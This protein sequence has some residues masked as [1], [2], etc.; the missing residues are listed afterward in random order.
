MEDEKDIQPPID[1][2]K[3]PTVVDEETTQD[4]LMNNSEVANDSISGASVPFYEELHAVPV[5]D[6]PSKEAAI[7]YSFLVLH[8]PG[9]P[10]Q[11]NEENLR[12][13]PIFP[14]PYLSG[15]TPDRVTQEQL[16][17]GVYINI[18]RSP[19]LWAG[20]Q[21]RLRWGYNTFYTTV[22]ESRGR[23]GPRLVQYL[24]S[25]RLGDY[26]DGI[27]EVL[28]EVVRRSRLIGVSETLRVELHGV[29]KTPRRP[30]SRTRAIRRR[31]LRP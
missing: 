5:T 16:I 20:D 11:D 19:K 2:Q 30:P 17:V 24:N 7:D 21:L 29:G 9:F 25:E 26:K 12:A 1:M 27:V 18:P 4:P 10:W 22:T 13:N 8:A 28:Y 31:K 23:T 15:D 6:S 3:K 14:A